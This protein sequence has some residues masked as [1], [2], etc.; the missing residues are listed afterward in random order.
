MNC[1]VY[2]IGSLL[3]IIN[4]HKV[5]A[6]DD[7]KYRNQW[8]KIFSKHLVHYAP[9]EDHVMLLFICF[10]VYSCTVSLSACHL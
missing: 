3:I 10:T 4:A 5:S 9:G 2:G 6:T 8:E 7:F 1:I